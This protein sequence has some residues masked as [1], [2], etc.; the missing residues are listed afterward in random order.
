[1]RV[2]ALVLGR[3][4]F[5]FGTQIRYNRLCLGACPLNKKEA[6]SKKTGR[7]GGAMDLDKQPNWRLSRIF[8]SS[9]RFPF[10]HGPTKRKLSPVFLDENRTP[11]FFGLPA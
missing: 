8:S 9:L 6:L 5:L 1:M 10:K 11:R 7:Y 2:I 3:I 4:G